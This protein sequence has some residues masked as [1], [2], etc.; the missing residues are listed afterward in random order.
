MKQIN[1]QKS[2]IKQKG[3]VVLLVSIVLL[4]G[5]TLIT[6]FA[7]RIGVMD[8]RISGNEYRHK[9]SQE[10]A[11]AALQQGAAFLSQNP[12][13]Y[14]GTTTSW[15]SCSSIQSTFPCTVNGQTYE[16][17]Y[18]SLSGSIINPL[19]YTTD[20]S[21]GVS[22]DT[23]ILFTTSVSVG[24]VL[25]VVGTGSSLDGSADSIAQIS[26]A[27]VAFLT[28]GE[29]P[30][31]MAPALQLKG[32]FT[33]VANPNSGV[34]GSGVP[35]SGWVEHWPVTAAIGD[36]QTCHVGDFRDGTT[37]C[38]DAYLSSDDWSGCECEEDLSNKDIANADASIDIYEQTNNFP[39]PFAYVFQNRDPRDVR[40]DFFTYGTVYE[41]D[42]PASLETLDL[43]STEKPW[44]WVDEDCT[45]PPI[46][47][48][49]EDGRSPPVLLV[50]AGQMTLN[51]N[52]NAWGLLVS[53]TDVQANGTSIVHGALV[54]DNTADI[55]AGTYKQVYDE[56]LLDKLTDPTLNTNLSKIK[57]SWR[58]F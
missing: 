7:A 4:L 1:P 40:G 6:I 10:A 32:N 51:G 54:A 17:V 12:D 34:A 23:Y 39:D 55:T 31:I 20:L 48:D 37:V 57:Y 15:T 24:N 44:V 38:A 3:A 16:K 25:T 45:V 13:L 52:T 36:W 47:G 53:L 8:Q 19:S 33:I 42:C 21:S 56:S 30:P 28:P 46:G 29:I 18:S 50:V 14:E 35:I 5:V 41:G 43:R 49:G 22:S 58:D 26:Y 9:E 27:K 2:I 11:A